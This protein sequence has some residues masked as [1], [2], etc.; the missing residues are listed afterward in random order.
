MLT[1]GMQDLNHYERSPWPKFDILNFKTPKIMIVLEQ[2]R[3]MTCGCRLMLP[4][5]DGE[6]WKERNRAPINVTLTSN[7]SQ[8]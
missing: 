7:I 8:G 6:I 3:G 4:T 5:A 1:F 2:E